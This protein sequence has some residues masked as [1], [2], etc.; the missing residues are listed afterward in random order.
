MGI[1]RTY[2]DKNN[3]IVKNSDVNTGR[4]QISELYFGVKN[5]RFL[6]YCSF[7]EIK[8]LVSDKVINIDNDTRHI[9]KIKNTS[10]FDIKDFLSTSNNLLFNDNYRPTSF[11]LELHAVN[12][13]W[14][15]G[16]GYD[17]TP[18]ATS[19]PENKDFALEPSNWFKATNTVSFTPSGAIP[20]GNTPIASQH[21]DLGNEDVEMD[22]TDFVND[23]ITTTGATTG[24]TT[25]TTYYGF[26]LK[27]S[28]D[29]EA[30]DYSVEQKNF[31]LGL[32]TRHTQTFFEPFIET[33]YNDHIEDDRVTFYLAKN[34]NLFFYSVIDGKL[35]NLDQLPTCK[36]NNVNYAV[37]QKTKGV[38]YAEVYGD[39]NVYTSYTEYNDIW[40][41]IVYNGQARPNT[42]LR[43][44]PIDADKYYNFNIDALDDT[45]YGLSLSGIRREEKL[46]QGEKRKVNILLRKP[47]TVSEYYVS[48]TVY[49]RMYVKQG[50][51][52]I[53]IVDWQIAN[54]SFNNNYF[55]IDTTWLVP[56]EYFIDIKVETG[57]ET[58]IFDNELS[59]NIVNK[60]R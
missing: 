56:Q 22:I 49:Y 59:F 43:F 13:F 46:S 15:E 30:L 38:Y 40:S 58:L 11:E 41:N 53:T 19:I 16:S 17:F 28:D 25:G 3:T 8:S 54:K 31:A 57:G 5:S 14:D 35:Q 6:F 52:V 1:Y 48:S 55:T 51:A 50:P 34:N 36:I 4:N 26:C 12:Q 23:Y 21:F 45:R 2:F 20:S 39:E 42:K 10:S 18:S 27:F 24:A 7:D 37:K 60:V 9:L 44:V 29:I 47:Y 33:Q 32:F